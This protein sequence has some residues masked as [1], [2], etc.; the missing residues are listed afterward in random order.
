ME[1]YSWEGWK[2]ELKQTGVEIWNE[3]NEKILLQDFIDLVE[4]KQQDQT[5]KSHFDTRYWWQD[6]EGYDF[7]GTEFS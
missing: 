5:N 3:Y 7:S 6:H 2:D 4:S 1:I